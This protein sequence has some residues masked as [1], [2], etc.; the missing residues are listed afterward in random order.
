MPVKRMKAAMQLL[1]LYNQM[2]FDREIPEET[3]LVKRL[4]K[5]GIMYI[6]FIRIVDKYDTEDDQLTAIY[7]E[8]KFRE[9]KEEDIEK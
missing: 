2:R 3:L 9:Y 7:Q 1:E 4:H 8:I 5:L 6:D